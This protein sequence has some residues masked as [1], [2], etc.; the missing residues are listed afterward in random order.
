[1]RYLTYEQYSNIG[2]TLEKSA[3][4]RVIF[5]A[6][7]IVDYYTQCRLQENASE[8]EKVQYCVRDLCEYI[9][10]NNDVKYK[11]ITTKSQSAGGVSESESYAQKSS[12]DVRNDMYDVVCMY[13]SAEVDNNGTP[14]MYKGRL[15]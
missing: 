13:L 6:C 11:A 3:F 12:D 10:A 15:K 14:L 2:G 8:N 7:A 5:A 9:D 4:E 1:M